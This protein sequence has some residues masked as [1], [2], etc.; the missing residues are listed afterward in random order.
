MVIP[1]PRAGKNITK[2]TAGLAGLQFSEPALPMVAILLPVD[3]L[4]VGFYSLCL[5]RF[6]LPT[7]I[8]TANGMAITYTWKRKRIAFWSG[9]VEYVKNNC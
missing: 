4:A 7:I 1:D 2:S 3:K 8:S 6:W 5:P 9:S